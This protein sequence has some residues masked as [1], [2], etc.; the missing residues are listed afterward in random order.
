MRL[1]PLFSLS[2][3]AAS[4][5]SGCG[6]IRIEERN[7]LRPDAPDRPKAHALDAAVLLPA[8]TVSEETLETPD[9]AVLRGITLRQAGATTALL[10]FGGNT[11]HLD[12]HGKGLL[13]H[14]AACGTNVALFDYRGYGR[15]SGVPTV[16]TMQADAL[17]IYD[18]VSARHPGGVVVH[19]MSLGSFMAGY[20]AQ[21][22]PGARA[23]VLEATASTVQ[24]WIDANVPWYARLFMTV[25]VDP[26]L[27]G[28]DNVQL[29]GGYRGTSLVL[30]GEKDK[31]TPPALGRRV[32]EALPG[33]RKQW[34]LADG[35]DH[36]GILRQPAVRPVY[37]G[38]VKT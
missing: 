30:A 9:G 26:S 15:S 18:H 28:I 11:F 2:F 20:V 17:R 33:E 5:I 36:N 24:D 7:F 14:L 29:V 32:F 1:M 22:R 38:V 6:T 16:A 35:A 25:S 19:G 27:R 10:Y 23:L 13:A 31:V 8:A 37:C 21:Q 12:E 34:F 3:L 4:L